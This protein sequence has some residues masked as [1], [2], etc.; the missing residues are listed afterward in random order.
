[1]DDSISSKFNFNLDRN[2]TRLIMLKMACLMA[3]A[4]ANFD[5]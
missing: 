1:M 3:M 2:L 4:Y 5:F